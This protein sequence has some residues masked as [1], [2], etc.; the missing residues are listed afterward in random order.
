VIEETMKHLFFD[1]EF[2]EPCWASLH[3]IWDLSLMTTDM[4]EDGKRHFQFDCYMRWS[5]WQRGV[6][7]SIETI[8]FSMGCR[9]PS[10]DGR[11]NLEIFSCFASIELN[12]V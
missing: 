9:F 1:C 11:K 3:F 7:G 12:L 6:F 8:L 10:S 5:F 4:I 2:A